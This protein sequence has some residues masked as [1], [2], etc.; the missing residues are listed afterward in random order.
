MN[1]ITQGH[2]NPPDPIDECIAPYADVIAESES[3]A[4]GEPVETEDQMN[5]VD[6]LIKSLRGYRSDLAKAQKSATAPL[7]DAW[8]AEIARWKPT[9]DDAK[10]LQDALTAVVAPFKAKLAAEKEAAKRAA[11]EEAERKRKEAEAAAA[12]INAADIE[13]Q[14][15]AGRLAQ[16]AQD[17]KE[18]ATKALKDTVKGMRTFR[19]P[20]IK[21]MGKVVNWI[22]RHD[23]TAMADFATEYVRK[24]FEAGIDG[25]EIITGK[26]A[27]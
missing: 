24:N 18:A 10:R 3:W 5:A 9:V 12:K 16:E 21:D 8:K 20:E 4:D 25:V 7:H 27:Y 13:A 19:R 22:A 11:F 1:M 2:N 23:K 17:A 15:E 6:A 14:R 26:E